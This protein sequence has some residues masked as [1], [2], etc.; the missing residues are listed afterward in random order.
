MAESDFDDVDVVVEFTLE[1]QGLR[2]PESGE[3][4]IQPVL[5]KF[6]MFSSEYVAISN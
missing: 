2:G 4:V 1:F 3:S 6:F 5:S